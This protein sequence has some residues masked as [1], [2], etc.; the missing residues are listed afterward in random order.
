MTNATSPWDN[1]IDLLAAIVARVGTPMRLALMMLTRAE[2]RD[3][4]RQLRQ[5]EAGVRQNLAPIIVQLALI[6]R[7]AA[8]CARAIARAA[9]P[10]ARH[11]YGAI[12]F[13]LPEPRAANTRPPVFR[14]LLRSGASSTPPT[15]HPQ[16]STPPTSTSQP[17]TAARR[18]QPA[19][20]S[21][22]RLATRLA[23]AVH[24]MDD[25]EAAA[26]DILRRHPRLA[27]PGGV[28]PTPPR[29]ARQLRE[30]KLQA[31]RRAAWENQKTREHER[32]ARI[33]A[34]RER[35]REARRL[36]RAQKRLA[37]TAPD[38]S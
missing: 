25:P 5:L 36:A 17:A 12:S 16:T 23:A 21:G 1:T 34:R 24:V 15:A 26:R 38:T 11:R 6:P 29:S 14:Y 30:D 33:E 35:E 32:R 37:G 7:I 18:P 22:L 13:D 10:K 19:E 4:D 31:R 28:P 9:K 8:A 20:R 2:H 27:F 3:L